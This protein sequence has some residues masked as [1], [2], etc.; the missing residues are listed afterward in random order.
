M[1]NRLVVCL[2]SVNCIFPCRVLIAMSFAFIPTHF[3]LLLL[4]CSSPVHGISSSEKCKTFLRKGTE[5]FLPPQPPHNY[6]WYRVAVVQTTSFF[7]QFVVGFFFGCAVK[8]KD[9]AAMTLEFYRSQKLSKEANDAEAI[10]RKLTLPV[11]HKA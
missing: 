4:V 6:C 11:A 8:T 10:A 9:N 1:E 7:P 3:L 2:V 5:Q